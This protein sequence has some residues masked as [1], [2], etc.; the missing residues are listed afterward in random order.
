[1][2]AVAKTRHKGKAKPTPVKP[3]TVASSI[4]ATQP[5]ITAAAIK[6]AKG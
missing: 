4:K 2:V 3:A 6:A 5:T 1:M